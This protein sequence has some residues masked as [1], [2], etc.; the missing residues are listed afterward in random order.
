MRWSSGARW[1]GFLALW[2]VPM[3]MPTRAVAGMLQPGNILVTDLAV[4]VPGQA[5]VF[6]VDHATGDRT[7]I[8]SSLVG[9]GPAF[10]PTAVMLDDAGMIIAADILANQ[11]LRIDPLTGNRT[12]VSGDSL[13]SGPM[14]T[15]PFD[16]IRAPDGAILVADGSVL[17]L[18]DSS[19]ILRVDPITGD[20]TMVSG[21]GVGTGSESFRTASD[22]VLESTTTVLVTDGLTNVLFRVDL[23][24]GDRTIVSGL[25]IGGGPMIGGAS[26]VTRA[27]DAGSVFLTQTERILQ[28][29]TSTGDRAL[30]SGSGV[31]GGPPFDFVSDIALA[32][33]GEILITDINENAL[34][35]VDA[36]TGDRSILSGMGVGSGPQFID[37]TGIFVVPI[38]EPSSGVLLLIGL[39]APAALIAKRSFCRTPK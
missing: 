10:I 15:A 17:S 4:E 31:G 24:T 36:G 21:E 12:I 11:I 29:D 37:P 38:P 26:A 27:I 1:M 13:G 8:S 39:L 14:F 16:V 5:A 20:R 28:V 34:F 23:L 33:S 22:M 32:I 3:L 6:K 35:A 19:K 30:V 18:G 2:L 7:V 25:G 9:T